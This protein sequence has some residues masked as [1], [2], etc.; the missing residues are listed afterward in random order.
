VLDP[1]LHL[2]RLV[3]PPLQLAVVGPYLVWGAWLPS[4]LPLEGAG[5]YLDFLGHNRYPMVHGVLDLDSSPRAFHRLG[6]RNRSLDGRQN[7]YSYVTTG[8]AAGFGG[9]AMGLEPLWP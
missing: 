8:T 7:R 9:A 2:I 6:G 1:S 4:H 5:S 3:V